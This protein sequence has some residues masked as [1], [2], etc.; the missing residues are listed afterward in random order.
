MSPLPGSL[1]LPAAAAI[2]VVLASMGL[3]LYLFRALGRRNR[4]HERRDRQ[5]LLRRMRAHVRGEAPA[6]ALLRAALAVEGGTFWAAL[7]HL[8]IGLPRRERRRLAMALAE[9]PHVSAERL[10]LA[11]ESPW[12]RELAARRLGL[13]G[14]RANRV[15]LRRALRRGPEVVTMAAGMALAHERD[16]AALRWLLRRPASLAHR[17]R[18]ALRALLA[19][20]GRRGLPEIAAGLERGID[21]PVLE[22]AAVD[23]VGRGRYRG[24]RDKLERMLSSGTLDQR[25]AAAR[26]LGLLQV[27]A[28]ATALLAALHDEAWPVRAQAARALGRAGAP[29]AV[30]ELA[31]RLTDRS[32]WVRRHSAYALA[33]LGA[34]G[35]DAL[36]RVAKTSSDP[37]ARDMAREVL[38]GGV[39]F[40]AA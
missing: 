18:A 9:S 13:L 36:H 24:A 11:D 30:P 14:S 26:A 34:E 25:V 15:A 35:R 5:A 16:L 2:L 37:Y 17:P 12:R 33:D 23:V 1:D 22:L 40:G 38:E 21:D 28:C 10:Q 27:E 32:W 3:A 19:A 4:R 6:D 7:E 20:Y 29:M 39:H 8:A 31:I